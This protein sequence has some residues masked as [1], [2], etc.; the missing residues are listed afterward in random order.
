MKLVLAATFIS[1]L[2][3]LPLASADE[4]Y[5]N[6]IEFNQ[7]IQING[8]YQQPRVKPADRLKKLRKK[9]EKQ[10][11]MMV[12]KQIE[13]MRLK[14]ELEMTKRLQ[15]IFNERMKALESL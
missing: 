9:L 13:S 4:S 3:L 7:P 1:Q 8:E 5:E 6:S 12:K 11:E 15:K 10:N 2:F 14:Q